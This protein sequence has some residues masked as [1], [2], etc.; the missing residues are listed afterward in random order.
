[1][2]VH[3]L[4]QINQSPP[5]ASQ[6]SVRQSLTTLFFK[7]IKTV[8]IIKFISLTKLICQMTS[9]TTHHQLILL[10]IFWTKQQNDGQ[11]THLKFILRS[12]IL[13]PLDHQDC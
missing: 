5:V 2:S 13:K 9:S 1:M 3:S 7:K 10:F 8:H 11:K 4:T 12:K 6:S